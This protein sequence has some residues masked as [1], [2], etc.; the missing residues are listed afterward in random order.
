MKLFFLFFIIVFVKGCSFDTKSGIWQT[1]NS[2][3]KNDES[4]FKEFKTLSS[5]NENFNKTIVKNNDFQFK[6]P[7][8]KNNLEWRDRYLKDSNNLFNFQYNNNNNLIFKGKKISGSLINDFLVDENENIILGDLKGNI[9]L[10]SKIENKI[11]HKFN[12]YQKKYKKLKKYLNLIIE[13]NIVYV[14]D[15]IGYLYAYDYK[16]NK[17]LWAKN[18]KIPFRSN[19]KITKEKLI[20]VNQNNMLFYFNKKTGE[21]IR[22]IPSEETIVKNEFINNLSLT[23]KNLFFLN[24]YGS[25][26][27]INNNNMRINWFVNLNKS[28]D[29][30]PANLFTGKEIIHSSNKIIVTTNDNLYVINAVSGSTI[31]KKNFTSLVKPLVIKDYIFLISR[32]NLLISI[33]LNNGEIIYS[34][35]INQKIAEFLNTKKKKVEFM[36]ILM[37]NNSI[38][39]FLKNSYVVKFDVNGTIKEIFKLPI[40]MNSNPK[41]INNSLIYLDKKNKIIIID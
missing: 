4:L 18:Y 13:N 20:A 11:L 10:F 22:S 15:N 16:A 28:L 26:Y 31:F 25:L 33:N 35:N 1:E 36:K 9:F 40:K 3:N 12:F 23:F 2:N 38:L 24:S 6:L 30:N 39:I 8:I 7:K 21:K 27:S 34:Y 32:N 14:S 17:V 19:L 37:A 41:I 5:E 29:I